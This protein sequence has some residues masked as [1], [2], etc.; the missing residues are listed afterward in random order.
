MQQFQSPPTQSIGLFGRFLH[1]LENTH[2]AAE[3][4]VAAVVG[5][6]QMDHECNFRPHIADG[7]GDYAK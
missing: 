3:L 1:K 2:A 7:S 4:S 6:D 5:G